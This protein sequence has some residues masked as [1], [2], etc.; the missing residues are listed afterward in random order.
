LDAPGS[1]SVLANTR[2]TPLDTS[3]S[4]ELDE[5]DPNPI[6]QLQCWQQDAIDAGLSHPTAMSLATADAD[7]RPSVRHVLCK[8]IDERGIELHTNY[9]SRKGRDLATNQ[10]AATVVPWVG[11]SRQATV[12]S[13]SSK[14]PVDDY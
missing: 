11:M 14:V 12:V 8:G 9:E 6:V 7:G 2:L 5:L 13:T 4:M 10:H 1:P 3:A